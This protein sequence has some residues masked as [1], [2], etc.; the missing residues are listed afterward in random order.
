M[1]LKKFFIGILAAQA[2]AVTAW[3]HHSHGAYS[4]VDYTEI[5]GTVTEVYWINP[6]TWVYLDVENAEGVMESWAMEA[7]GAT[8]LTRAGLSND[9][10]QPGDKIHVRCHPLRDG[11][12]GCLLGYVTTESGEAIE[13]D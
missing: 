4:M 6:H 10:V 8:T 2:V 5:E 9:T 1:Q 7:A 12:N 13:W 3:A 11:S